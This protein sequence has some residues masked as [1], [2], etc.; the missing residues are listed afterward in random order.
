MKPSTLPTNPNSFGSV[1]DVE[2]LGMAYSLNQRLARW[3]FNM[4]QDVKIPDSP[5][6]QKQREA[7]VGFPNAQPRCA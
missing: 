7:W 1:E 2:G 3:A 6:L 5:A 4:T